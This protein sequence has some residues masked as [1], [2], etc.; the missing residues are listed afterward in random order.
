MAGFLQ[1]VSSFFQAIL[2]LIINIVVGSLQLVQ[3]IPTGLNYLVTSIGYMPAAFS[4]VA[5]ALV[6][7]SVVYLVI[8]R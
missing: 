7:L 4:A 3:M 2:S 8:G 5:F 1:S 6:T